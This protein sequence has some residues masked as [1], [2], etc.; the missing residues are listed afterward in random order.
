MTGPVAQIASLTVYSNAYLSGKEPFS[1]NLSNSTAQFC[2]KIRYVDWV[3]KLFK[4]GEKMLAENPDDW[5]KLLK[6]SGVKY[7]W[8]HYV[9]SQNADL[10]DR[11][12]AGFVGGGGRWLIEA[13]YE[14][15]S[16]YW[17]ARWEVGN[18][19][20]Q[21][22]RIW[23]VT[24]GRISR[25]DIKRQFK[26]DSLVTVSQRLEQNLKEIKGF[27][28][29]HDIKHFG[30]CFEKGLKCLNSPNPL[31][32]V[33]HKDLLPSSFQSMELLQ[34]LCSCQAAWVFGGMGSWNDM[35]FD[36]DEQEVYERVSDA[37][38]KTICEAIP[39]AVNS[40]MKS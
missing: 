24:Y 34:I 37:L 16:D 10:K 11:Y 13:G 6:N 38:Y 8:L 1:F 19:D 7:L 36:G 9:P 35:D 12:S 30:E 14:N 39:A 40:I 21:N 17:E 26:P 33:Y 32:F 28:E 15:N 31:E 20:A 23:I 25:N 18:K 5:V 22:K 4:N 29:R 27:A 3:K 2:E